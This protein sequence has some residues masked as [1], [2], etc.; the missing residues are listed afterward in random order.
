MIIN[1]TKLN[2]FTISLEIDKKETVY[3]LKEKIKKIIDIDINKQKL[4]LSC[5]EMFNKDLL[6]SYRIEESAAIY[7]STID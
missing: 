2:G 1:I 4:I 5:K 3:V 7:L 6:E